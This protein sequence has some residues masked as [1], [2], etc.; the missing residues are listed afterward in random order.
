M[1]RMTQIK[2]L[3]LFGMAFALAAGGA[4]LS[5]CGETHT[6]HTFGEWSVTAPTCTEEGERVRTC[7]IEGCN[8][9][10]RE[11]IPALGHDFDLGTVTTPAT[12]TE[13]GVR[14]R[15]CRRCKATETASVSHLNHDWDG[16]TVRVPATCTS[17]GM[18]LFTCLRCGDS[19]ERPTDP[20]EHDWEIKRVSNP[21][22]EHTGLETY[23]C[24]TCGKSEEHTLEAL[25]HLWRTGETLREPTCEGTGL[26]TDTCA[27]CRKSED[28][29]IK[30]LGHNWEGE[31][32][33][34][35]K[36]SFEGPGEKS[37]HCT[38]CEERN[39]ITEI[40]MLEVNTPIEYEF[41]LLRN[42][43]AR[44]S[45]AVSITVRD[46]E[47]TIAAQGGRSSFEGGVFKALLL[48]KT[49]TV[50][51]TDLPE[52][53]TALGQYSV[54]AADP[55]CRLYLT[56]SPIPTP[57]DGGTRYQVGSV[58]HE[59]TYPA[60]NSTTGELTLS[61]I[62]GEKRML[63]INFWYIDCPNCVSEFQGLER[64]Y[65]K[66]KNIAE[67]IAVN[68]SDTMTAISDFSMTYRLTFPMVR[69]TVRLSAMF[70]VTGYPTSVVI[71]SE[72]VVCEIFTGATPEERFESYFAAYT[73]QGAT[74]SAARVETALP[75]RKYEF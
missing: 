49:Y 31:Y 54:E 20:I 44:L 46:E 2:Q 3:L 58:L 21:D 64:V 6:A 1:K 57:A 59:F 26:R 13:A 62:L 17:G 32:T 60:Q 9:T 33:I 48:P 68:P 7:T 38:R 63:L 66:Y 37:Y 14:T 70:G 25:D 11:P 65:Q 50:T 28:H 34:D 36:P 43:G 24:R 71:D 73:A 27:R 51:L 69:D 41:R 47:G 61:G 30:A 4:A 8:E 15:T 29:E 40:P 56:A 74:Q 67:V 10:E 72:G 19:E 55:V 42:S 35:K 75:G 45:A 18:S 23:T 52:G 22:C 39:G 12:C 5:A 53:Y 16:G